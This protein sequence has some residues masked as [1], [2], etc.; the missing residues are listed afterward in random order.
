MNIKKVALSTIAG[1]MILSAAGVGIVS[2]DDNAMGTSLAQRLAER[3]GLN[4]TEVEEVLTEY[5]GQYGMG[6][7]GM[8]ME[9]DEEREARMQEHLQELVDEG[10]LT[11][12]QMT[13]MLEHH[14][15]M[16]AQREANRDAWQDLSREERQAQ[17]EQHRA[18]EEAWLTEQG[19]DP[20]V[21]HPMGGPGAKGMGRGMGQG[22]HRSEQ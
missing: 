5:R 17:A 2:A 9:S 12:E 7:H 22:M 6:P 20:E 21:V 3:F 14:E 4:Q 13:L 18:Q 10:S 16:E 11:Q 8:G 15:E 1:V 19:I